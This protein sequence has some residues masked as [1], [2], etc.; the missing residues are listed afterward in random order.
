MRNLLAIFCFTRFCAS[1]LKLYVLGALLTIYLLGPSRAI[2]QDGD[3]PPSAER[4]RSKAPYS[5]SIL[6][7]D[8]TLPDALYLRNENGD[9]IFIPQVRYEEFERY[10]K[11][12]SGLKQVDLPPALLESI[13]VK[14]VIYD[15]YAQLNIELSMTITDASAT[16]VRLPLSMRN[17][18]WLGLPKTSGG[19]S[20]IVVAGSDDEGV[21][22]RVEPDGSTKY[23]LAL[24]AVLKTEQS[25]SESSLRL[26]LPPS[27]SHIQLEVPGSDLNL[28]WLGATGEVLQKKVLANSTQADIR[29]RGGIGTLVWSDQI[30]SRDLGA[31]EVDSTTRLVRSQDGKL[32]RGSTLLRIVSDKRIGPRELVV[33]L[34]E[35]ARWNPTPT[36]GVATNWT[37][38]AWRPTDQESSPPPKTPSAVISDSR[39]RL[40]LQLADDESDTIEEIP[41]EWTLKTDD[42]NDG[43]F[44]I[45]GIEVEGVQRH[46]GHFNIVLPTMTRFSWLPS[47]EY[48]LAQQLPAYDVTDSI[49]YDFRFNR[50]PMRLQAVISENDLQARWRPDYWV[51]LDQ[52]AMRLQGVVTFSDGPSQLFGLNIVGDA[53]QF[54]V[55]VW[56]KTGE[57]IP[58]EIVQGNVLRLLPNSLL[59]LDNQDIED[60]LDASL[61]IAIRFLASQPLPTAESSRVQ[62]QLPK[63]SILAN[64]KRKTERGNGTLVVDSGSWKI[65]SNEVRVQGMAR[66]S[67]SPNSLRTILSGVPIDNLRI[68]R[69]Q[70]TGQDPKWTAKVRRTPRVISVAMETRVN[71]S[72]DEWL[73]ERRWLVES[74]GPTLEK[75][76]IRIPASW[77]QSD[78]STGIELISDRITATLDGLPIDLKIAK[79]LKDDW[80]IVEPDRASWPE[81]FEFIIRSR[82]SF[83]LGEAAE[84]TEA[85][86]K[87]RIRILLPQLELTPEAR[88]FDHQSSIEV[89]PRMMC[90]VDDAVSRPI[91]CTQQDRRVAFP[92]GEK[93]TV[94]DVSVSRL[95]TLNDN[96]IDIEHIWLQSVINGQQR[97]ERCVMRLTT[98]QSSIRFSLPNEWLASETFLLL[99]GKKR[100]LVRDAELGLYRLELSSEANDIA[101]K[102]SKLLSATSEAAIPRESKPIVIEFWNWSNWNS[103]WTTLIQAEFPTIQDSL[104][105]APL[106]WHVLLP[107]TEHLWTNSSTLLSGQR[108]VWRNL[109]WW[110]ESSVSQRDAELEFGASVQPEVTTQTNQ[111]VFTS[112]GSIS[113]HDGTIRVLPRYLLWLPVALTALLLASIWPKMGVLGHPWLLLFVLVI[114][115]LLS[116][117]APDI[118]I[119]LSQSAIASL[120]LVALVKV[121]SWASRQRVHRRSVFANRSMTNTAGRP[122]LRSFDEEPSATLGIKNLADSVSTPSTHAL[123]G[124]P[125]THGPEVQ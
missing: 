29:G 26:E 64:G 1:L 42:S 120:L 27:A 30:V 79:H 28:Q 109:G 99:N 53:W 34:P 40:R 112:L 85:D 32:Y 90:Q 123:E 113:G 38:N 116:M 56:D 91:Q 60:P 119:I 19:K 52:D 33:R 6:Q 114:L 81:T 122:S 58:T 69:F 70:S 25:F 4:T 107:T 97:R 46:E 83:D 93:S 65:D 95:D 13:D 24:E 105:P 5:S 66:S 15:G 45:L 20:S 43:N 67:E 84:S 98:R 50:Q 47:S 3:S 62:F 108:W 21:I 12:R 51:R 41:I 55:C 49:E 118:T 124:L 104:H 18:N 63:I 72:S 100:E 57:L 96:K 61:P 80:V 82:D 94:V 68:F 88:I 86:S 121:V 35:N 22:W 37:L 77:V 74:R 110:R 14:G 17:M 31:V 9:P 48:S 103:Q 87:K 73:C 8:T 78:D 125:S 39:E 54:D 89:G 2:A 106:Q 92:L 76:P 10:L 7:G 102:A 36:N 101:S 16:L 11:E 117:S 23:T 59:S 115:A 71:V 44:S 75:L 111:Y